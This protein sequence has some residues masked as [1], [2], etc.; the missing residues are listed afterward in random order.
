[1]CAVLYLLERER[2]GDRKKD[3]LRERE[4]KKD[5]CAILAL[6]LS[7]EEREK[8][9]SLMRERERKKE[10]CAILCAYDCVKDW[11]CVCV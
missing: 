1:L 8:L 5:R 4:R 9:H 7:H 3:A 11:S 6:F 2:K 10:R